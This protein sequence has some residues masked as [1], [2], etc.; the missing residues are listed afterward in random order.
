MTETEKL[1]LYQEPPGLLPRLEGLLK[2]VLFGITVVVLALAGLELG[3]IAW[4]S[5]DWLGRF[6][7][8]WALAFGAYAL[9]AGLAVLG[10]M[11]LFWGSV[12]A[13]RATSPV[14][15]LR[16][17]LGWARWALAGLA[18]ALPG[19]F[20]VYTPWGDVFTG[21]F[22]RLLLYLSA[23]VLAGFFLTRQDELLL[24]WGQAAA[25]FILTG[26]AILLADSFVLVRGYPFSLSWSEGNRIWDYSIYFAGDLYNFPPGEEI[27]AF[28]DRGRQ[29]LWGL[30][31]AL[32]FQSIVLSRFWSAFLFTIPYA[33]LGW[34]AFP[35]RKGLLAVWLLTGLWVMIFLGQGPIYTPLVLS[36]ILVAIAFR[37]RWLWLALALVFIASFYAQVA[38]FTWMFA[39]AMWAGMLVLGS[40]MLQ[41]GKIPRREWVRAVAL[42]GVAVLGGYLLPN[43]LE[44]APQ[45]SSDDVYTF[46]GISDFIGRQALLWYRLLPSAT[47]NL[48]IL[49]GLLLAAGPLTALL[50]FLAATRR[51]ALNR[52]QKL[53]IILPLLAFLAVGLIISVK[54]GGG[55]NLHNLDMFLIGLIFAA[56]LSW[57]S[58]GDRLIADLNRGPSALRLLVLLMA[59]LPALIPLWEAQPLT[60]PP[61]ETTRTTLE[62][63]QREVAAAS[64]R[65]EVLM[66]DQRQLL[67]FGQIA[68]LPL[69]DEYEKKYLMD[70]ALTG[71]AAYFEGF[72]SDLAAA[73]F[74]LILSHP[75]NVD[76]QGSARSFGEE[77]DAWDFWVG[78][79]LLCYYEPLETFK[80]DKIQLLVPRSSPGGNCP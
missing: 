50:V 3:R 37:A 10:M 72:Y 47:N 28:I 49:P 6:S 71:D 77:N 57:S 35:H 36:A 31:F 73:R 68:R 56:S 24:G 16:A 27:F 11:A 44:A 2:A 46:S 59:A 48:G 76:V 62:T 53:A 43:L 33:I 4:G 32:P 29:T 14:L 5:G 79:A 26:S 9:F 8:K 74:S 38:R 69:V 1:P 75:I 63:I 52:L 30:P 60:L 51:W 65:G 61:E 66:M 54:I 34:I 13:E 58:G 70:Q 80:E 45:A 42:T 15:A 67:T 41:D 7:F 17:R 40:N 78:R 25:G 23:A 19:L 39:P 20:L 22:L 18:A 21:P 64:E 55:N 12:R